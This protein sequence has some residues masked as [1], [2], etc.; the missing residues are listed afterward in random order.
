[1]VARH[2][3]NDETARR[4]II[5]LGGSR[6]Q[7]RG[8]RV[9]RPIS[10][11]GF[12]K[13]KIHRLRCGT[14]AAS[15]SLT[16]WS[17]LRISVPSSAKGRQNVDRI[18]RAFSWSLSAPVVVSPVEGGKFAII[19]GQHRATSAALMGFDSVPCQIVIAAR[20]KQ[21]AAFKAINGT[22]TP[23]SQMALHAAA[24][25]AK[26]TMSRSRMGP[27]APRW[28]SYVTRPRRTNRR[29]GKRWLSARSLGV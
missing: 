16:S 3:T 24:L 4:R 11:E 19:D 25:V 1:M 12:E 6:Q 2:R 7:C 8:N 29:R 18:A 17:T 10:T 22:T 15:R 14:H 9:M 23:I 26:R 13:L 28:S 21:V 5:R 27:R 20:E